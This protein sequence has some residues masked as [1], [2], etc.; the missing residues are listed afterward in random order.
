MLL[1]NRHQGTAS[2][3]R[4]ATARHKRLVMTMKWVANE[5]EATDLMQVCTVEQEA[6]VAEG[7]AEQHLPLQTPVHILYLRDAHTVSAM[8]SQAFSKLPHAVIL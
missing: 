2:P 6:G 5:E 3:A 1:T 7:L 4:Q 8:R